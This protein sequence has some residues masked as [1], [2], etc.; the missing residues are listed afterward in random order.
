SLPRPLH[1]IAITRKESLTHAHP[2]HTTPLLD[3]GNS[4]NISGKN[5][6]RPHRHT[7]RPHPRHSPALQT[8]SPSHITQERQRNRQSSNIG[9]NSG[10][11]G[12]QTCYLSQS[13]QPNPYLPSPTFSLP[14]SPRVDNRSNISGNISGKI[15]KA[16]RTPSSPNS[17]RLSPIPP[18]AAPSPARIPATFRQYLPPLHIGVSHCC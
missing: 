6:K 15:G 8:F 1:A 10:N 17:N 18:A 14:A 9:K 3:L 7:K 4:G 13:P 11:T 16:D 5:G 2:A 12:K